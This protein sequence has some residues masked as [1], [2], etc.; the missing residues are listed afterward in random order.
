[1]K[2]THNSVDTD[3]SGGY[4]PRRQEVM[5]NPYVF[6]DRWHASSPVVYASSI[7]RYLVARDRDIR[8]ACMRHDIFSNET[9]TDK[10]LGED[11]GALVSADEPLHTKQRNLV[12]LAFSP[13]RV[14]ESAP[15]ITVLTDELIDAFS[16][17]GEC[18]LVS[19]FAI[20]IPSRVIAGIL[21]IPSADLEQIQYWCDLGQLS[22]SYPE[23]F[24]DEAREAMI[25]YSGY[26]KQLI[27]LKQ[28]ADARGKPEDDLITALAAA[29]I[30]GEKLREWELLQIIW[31]L[32]TAGYET[33]TAL[34]ANAVY[35]LSAH[36]DQKE[37][38]LA[39]PRLIEPAIEEVLR[40]E[41]STLGVPRRMK[42]DHT[43]GGVTIPAG[44]DVALMTGSG[45]RDEEMWDNPDDFDI[46]RPRTSCAD[47]SL[48]GSAYTPV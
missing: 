30:D 15:F 37:K 25:G 22:A 34:I 44:C 12:N 33:T 23:K 5:D 45:N 41:P 40:Q 27:E 13:K 18:E 4:D 10:G 11:A 29:E 9:G 7:D 21:G 43:L 31:L 35:L 46:T 6:Y 8:E 39:D 36:P 16:A 3:T 32:M 17:R 28:D 38:L 24:L 42:K 47:I 20:R 2:K 1:M 19:D 48:S 26:M 14:Q